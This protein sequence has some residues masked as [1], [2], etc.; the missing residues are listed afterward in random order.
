MA[1]S[2]EVQEPKKKRSRK[3][4]VLAAALALVVPAAAW[5]FLLKPTPEK[6]PLPGEVVAL[7]PIQVNLSGGHYLRVGLAL[8]LTTEVVEEVD[9]SK[10]LDAA[11]ALYSGRPVAEV[12]E[13]KKREE[14]KQELTH[15]IVELYEGEL[16][17]I[18]ITEFVTQ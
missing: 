8:Q 18:Y 9:G 13:A 10:A 2:L 1:E 5:W 15:E 11:I 4:L 16:M 12:S 14:L 3:K 17:G 7:E 6:A